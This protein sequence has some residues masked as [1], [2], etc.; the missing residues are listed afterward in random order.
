MASQFPSPLRAQ[1]VLSPRI[2]PSL[3]MEIKTRG[4]AGIV[5]EAGGAT[6][7]GA[8]LARS[9]GVPAVTGIAHVMRSVFAGDEVIVDGT[10]GR[11]V[12]RPSPESLAL[13]E[14]EAEVIEHRRTEFLRYR[15]RPTETADGVRVHLHANVALGVDIALAKEN[16]AEGIGLYRTEFP[17][18]VR[19]GFPTIDEQIQIY[20]KAYDAFPHGPIAFRLLDLAGDKF[21]PRAEI[22]ASASA[23]HGYR[24]IRVLFDYPEL[25]RDQVQAF[26]IAAGKRPLRILVPMVTSLEDV[27]R[28]K[29]MIENA[30]REISGIELQREPQ[31]GVMIEV[32][33]AV[34]MAAD[35]AAE[36]DFLSIGTNDLIQ[37]TL[38]ADREDSRMTSPRDAYHPAIL[39]MLKRTVSAVHASGKEV[40]VCGEMAAR[41]DL[42]AFL[43]AIGVDALSVNP[44]AIPELKQALAAIE[45]KP[46][47]T[48][49]AT[50]AGR[51]NATETELALR[52]F[53]KA[54]GKTV[55]PR[56]LDR[57]D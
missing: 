41:P 18:I 51:R 27:S 46:L 33:A 52:S 42:A 12:V 31:I 11:V 6:S 24:S 45:V 54:G 13:Y 15:E 21:V 57:I 20:R 37:Y 1:V 49:A 7:H 9:L 55:E 32:P 2:A 28:I 36:V 10:T 19:E 44:R 40:S 50:I 34:E 38:V 22:G 26:A 35:L 25:L 16:G 4:A 53:L 56:T 17:F 39:R 43:V 30:L 5:T 29:L 3:V 47:A 14:R 8:L 23:F 48:A